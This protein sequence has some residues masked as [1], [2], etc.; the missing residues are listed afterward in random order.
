MLY[1][2]FRVDIDGEL[3]YNINILLCLKVCLMKVC[4]VQL[5]I[6]WEDKEAN[7]RR[8]R[9]L[10]ESASEQGAELIVFPEMSLTGFSMEASLAEPP[11]GAS[12][13]FFGALAKKTGVPCVFGYAER[14]GERMYN[15]LALADSDGEIKAR[16]AK[17]HPFSIGGEG[18]F[19]GGDELVSFSL[20][21]MEIGLT[22]CY[23]L[24]FPELYAKLSESCAAVIVSANFPAS[25][26]EHWLTL[27]R[28]RAIEDQ[29]YILGCNRAG[30]GGGIDYSGDSV[31]FTPDGTELSR[32]AGGECLLF[33]DI[34]ADVVYDVRCAFPMKKDRRIDIYRNFYE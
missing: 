6:V 15:R 9:E 2:Q 23:D 10:A 11:D 12:C 19:T 18:C 13:S 22:V 29:C 28:A 25:R 4:L 31:V 7:M 8:C 1:R 17:L 16:Y 27:L 33:S 5:D 3:L 26:R 20:G 30:F 14:D 34:S 24:R 32:A 21:G